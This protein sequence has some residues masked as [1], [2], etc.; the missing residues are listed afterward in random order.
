M[1]LGGMPSQ[2]I[3]QMRQIIP[4][5][6]GSLLGLP[7]TM[8]L[9]GQASIVFPGLRLTLVDVGVTLVL[10]ALVG[11]PANIVPALQATRVPP[12]EVGRTL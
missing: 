5:V 7:I 8:F 4:G 10:V 1:I 12:S 3:V 11:V 2:S 6:L 9:I